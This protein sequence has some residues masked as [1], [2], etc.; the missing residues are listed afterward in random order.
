MRYRTNFL[1]KVIFRLDFDPV[2]ALSQL[3]QPNPP[4]P[5]SGRIAQQ[6]PVVRG[7]PT[8]LLNVNIGPLGAGIQQQATGMVWEHRRVENGTRLVLLSP[9]F[10]AIEYGRG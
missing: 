9:D 10:L 3:A 5:F 7:Q 1:T 4:P 8:A 2:P 6:F